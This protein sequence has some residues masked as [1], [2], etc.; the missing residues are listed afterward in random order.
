[1][2]DFVAAGTPENYEAEDRI[3]V[4]GCTEYDLVNHYPIPLMAVVAALIWVGSRLWK[5][6][7][8]GEPD[9]DYHRPA[10]RKEEA[11]QWNEL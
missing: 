11:A 2:A 8:L 4:V 5:Y 1:M 10:A 7:K 6:K 9:A 3:V